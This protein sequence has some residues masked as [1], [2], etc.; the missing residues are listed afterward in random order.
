MILNKKHILQGTMFTDFNTRYWHGIKQQSETKWGLIQN[1]NPPPMQSLGCKRRRKRKLISCNCNLKNFIFCCHD[2]SKCRK[3][4]IFF[5]KVGT[6]VN[7][8]THRW[9]YACG[10]KSRKMAVVLIFRPLR[11]SWPFNLFLGRYFPVLTFVFHFC[12]QSVI[13]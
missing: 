11:C 10:S 9:A 5:V 8:Y 12:F 1:I 3:N 2:Y 6:M 4:E 7:G 13:L